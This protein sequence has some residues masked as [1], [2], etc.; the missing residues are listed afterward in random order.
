MRIALCDDET[1]YHETIQ[2]LMKDYKLHH[3][4]HSLSLSAF[5]SGRE[6]LN[7]VDQYGGF[8]LYILDCIMPEMDGI[9]AGRALRERGE[10]GMII[11]LTSSPALPWIP[12][13]WRRLIIF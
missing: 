5:S 2:S 4:D 8:D 10:A 6:L 11:Y 9:E 1:A 13:R 12:I 7:H 3:P